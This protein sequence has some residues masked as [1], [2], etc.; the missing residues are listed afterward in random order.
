MANTLNKESAVCEQERRSFLEDLQRFHSGR[1]THFDIIPNIG[2]REIDLH[3]LYRRVVEL[4]GWRKVCNELKWDE[5]QAEFG[6]PAACSNGDQGL[7]VI[8]VRFL[9]LY[10]KLNF[11]GEDPDQKE[12][13]NDANRHRKKNPGPFYGVPLK[14][15]YAQHQIPDLLRKN[16]GFC[17]D[18]VQPNDYDK[19]EKALLSGL[20]NEVDFAIN[21]CTLLSNEGRH[22]LRLDKAKHLLQ[23]LLAHIG[24]FN[25]GYESLYDLYHHGWSPYTDRD[26]LR[27]WY[28]SVNDPVIKELITM[29]DQIYTQK[30]KTGSEVLHLGH[31]IGVHSVEGQRVTQLAVL[32]RNLSFEDINQKLMASNAVVFKFLMLCVHSTYGSLKQLALDTLG[33]LAAQMV[34]DSIGNHRTN[35]ILDFI[36]KS[37]CADDKITVVRALEVLGKLCQVEAN[38]S[39]ITETLLSKTYDDVFRL[40]TVHDIQL[41]VHTLEALYQLSE[42]GETTTNKI[43]QVRNAVDIL[44]DLITVEAQSYGPN[45]LVGIKVV[46]YV[47]APTARK[48]GKVEGIQSTPIANPVSVNI[49]TPTPPTTPAKTSSTMSAPNKSTQ[50]TDMEATT[51][52]WMLGC[53]ESRRIGRTQQIEFFSEYLQFCHKFSLPN[54]LPSTDFLRLVKVAFPQ[55]ET[56]M[57]ANESGDKDIVFLGVCK[58]ANPK[59]FMIT[60]TTVPQPMSVSVNLQGGSKA[61]NS[62]PVGT[63]IPTPTLRQ[64]LM[65][66]PRHPIHPPILHSGSS[67]TPT[68][69]KVTQP[70]TPRPIAPKPV[71]SKQLQLGSTFVISQAPRPP[72][73]QIEVSLQNTTPPVKRPR[74]AP[75]GQIIQTTPQFPSIQTALQGDGQQV[76]VKTAALLLEQD[77]TKS[78]DTNLI[79]SLLAKKLS[80]NIVGRQNIPIGATTSHGLQLP[81][82][83]ENLVQQAQQQQ[84][85]ILAPTAGG[86]FTG[87]HNIIFTTATNIQTSQ[88]KESQIIT[89]QPLT[90]QVPIEV[91][92][93][94]STPIINTV[95]SPQ[96]ISQNHPNTSTILSQTLQQ[97]TST[98]ISQSRTCKSE[99]FKVSEGTVENV[100]HKGLQDSNSASSNIT[101]SSID[102]TSSANTNK[103]SNGLLQQHLV[104]SSTSLH[105]S[106]IQS[107]PSSVVKTNG[108]TNHSHCNDVKIDTSLSGSLSENGPL[109]SDKSVKINGNPGLEE[110]K[111]LDSETISNNNRLKGGDAVISDK[112]LHDIKLV[113]GNVSSP[114]SLE[115][116]LPPS[117]ICL[118][119]IQSG[120]LNGISDDSLDSFSSDKPIKPLPKED[121]SKIIEKAAKMNGI[122]N[123]IG[124]GDQEESMDVD[125]TVLNEPNCQNTISNIQFQNHNGNMVA[126]ALRSTPTIP[127]VNGQQAQITQVPKELMNIIVSADVSPAV[128]KIQSSIMDD[129]KICETIR[130]VPTPETRDGEL[131][132]DSFAS[133]SAESVPEK[134]STPVFVSVAQP[135]GKVADKP[136]VVGSV[137]GE[138]KGKSRKRRQSSTGTTSVIVSTTTTTVDTKPTQPTPQQIEF[139]CQWAGCNRCFEN[140]K[141]VF[142]HVVKTHTLVGTDGFCQW[143]QCPQVK[144]Q[145]WSL[146]THLQ[147]H[148]CSENALR[149]SASKRQQ[150]TTS[151]PAA[152]KPVVAVQQPSPVV[153]QQQCPAVN[154][155]PTSSTTATGIDGKSDGKNALVY[156]NDAAMQAIKRFLVKP[157]FPEFFETREGPVTK[158]IRL[159]AAL[160]LRNI[161]RYSPTGRSQIKKKEPQISYVT[162]SAVESSTALA[163]CLWEILDH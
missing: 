155:T 46:E 6:I 77:T 21:V 43:V 163:S 112:K 45:S 30:E 96:S 36:T 131:S 101:P 132:S 146:I 159:T 66:P 142:H 68:S 35:L 141:S 14:Y 121:I 150:P 128:I 59:P 37:F 103:F 39:Y 138:K 25:Q 162:M 29:N 154:N 12:T 70:V 49:P 67:A 15:N 13:E 79:K 126:S 102:N 41:I 137:G 32:L 91:S 76:M 144:R 134:H 98:N 71:A 111:V 51:L 18:L 22:V 8:Y 110:D 124:N 19:L 64:R 84:Q 125:Q 61:L 23:L 97:P 3:R 60:N 83:V 57:K 42:L 160:I 81:E 55:C 135:I 161:A 92:A 4:G 87:Q 94:H 122:T 113:N 109:P 148:H 63:N 152:R 10:E 130:H 56:K 52:S 62:S 100:Y 117:P 90:T 78:A 151:T 24:V 153:P 1:G 108:S 50:V 106:T 156:P 16:N 44:I 48:E 120:L 105:S 75:K 129:R 93:V 136:A 2:G 107:V 127:I 114:L 149:V 116:D 119:N 86:D 123:H 34:L 157:P 85:F 99:V 65:E 80:Q 133:S 38:E 158:H 53:Y 5:L 40:L 115:S 17:L 73:T 58:R 27:F 11:L 69:I 47:P 145:R 26:F 88:M 74:I 31:N 140:A 82:S 72:G 7:K 147:D 20:P 89:N 95:V 104:S 28:E 9:Y 118:N 139:Q 143:S 54:A 33:N